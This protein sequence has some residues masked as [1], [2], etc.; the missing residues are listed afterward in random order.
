MS[1]PTERE[2]LLALKEGKDPIKFSKGHRRVI[3]HEIREQV[4][5]ARNEVRRF[6][7]YISLLQWFA[8]HEGIKIGPPGTYSNLLKMLA[9]RSL[10]EIPYK[11]QQQFI[12]EQNRRIKFTRS[13][14]EHKVQQMNAII[15]YAERS[16]ASAVILTAG[17][18]AMNKRILEMHKRHVKWIKEYRGRL[19]LYEIVAGRESKIIDEGEIVTPLTAGMYQNRLRRKTIQRRTALRIANEMADRGIFERVQY[20]KKVRKNGKILRIKKIKYR[21]TP[22]GEGL[23]QFIKRPSRPDWQP[24]PPW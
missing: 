9:A 15:D 23:A 11:E 18:R 1:S 20:I 8:D 7:E 13:E 12:K 5:E 21:L 17:I 22:W 4:R 6:I 14:V 24:N 16:V 3:R 2:Y 10:E 19:L